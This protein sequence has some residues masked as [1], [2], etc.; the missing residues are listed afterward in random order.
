MENVRKRG[1]VNNKRKRINIIKYPYKIIYDVFDGTNLHL[2]DF[3]RCMVAPIQNIKDD[4]L[5]IA[6]DNEKYYD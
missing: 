2:L 6:Y 4:C 3:E 5:M 1:K